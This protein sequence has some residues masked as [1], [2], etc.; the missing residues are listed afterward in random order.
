MSV[1]E[2]ESDSQFTELTT[3]VS[4]STLIIIYF[5]TPWAAPCAQMNS[6]FKSL[7]EVHPTA[8][9][10]SVNADEFPD[11]SESFDVSAVPY[12]VLV[13]DST[14]LKELSGADPKELATSIQG[15]LEPGRG[16]SSSE[17]P[18][19]EGAASSGSAAAAGDQ[20]SQQQ[21]SAAREEEESEAELNARLSKLVSAAPVMLFMKGTPASPQCGFSRQLVAILREH[22]VRFGFFDILKDNSVRQGLKTF[23]DW[24][25]FPQLYVNGELQGGLDII[26]ESVQEDP[27]FFKNAL[28]GS[29]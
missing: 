5:N 13:R 2:I 8:T 11:I 23:S 26:R 25:T 22:Q 1:I 20:Q 29:A 28:E 18:A 6:V 19:A 4:P 21:P 15:L 17:K 24:P 9:F 16:S 7:A 14:I 12:F 27:D 3:S 10:V